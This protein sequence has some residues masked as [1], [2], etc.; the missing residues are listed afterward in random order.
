[1]VEVTARQDRYTSMLL[2]G[3]ARGISEM[4]HHHCEVGPIHGTA[5]EACSQSI[6]CDAFQLT[7]PQLLGTASGAQWLKY[8]ARLPDGRVATALCE[9][10]LR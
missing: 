5:P 7:N 10:A 6:A 3:D 8:A 2:E 1:M 4:T 9:V